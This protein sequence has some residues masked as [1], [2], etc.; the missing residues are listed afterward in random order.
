MFT[1]ANAA[2][3]GG[4]FVFLKHLVDGESIYREPIVV[5]NGSRIFIQCETANLAFNAMVAWSERPL[6]PSEL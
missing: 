4:S 5:A 6:S 3:F 1:G 2:L